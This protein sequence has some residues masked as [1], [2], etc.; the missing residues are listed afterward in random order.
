MGKARRFLPVFVLVFLVQRAAFGQQPLHWDATI[1]TA[2]V[3]ACQS[4]RLVLVLFSAPWCTACHHL[5]NDIRNQP[6]AVAALEGNYV[7]VKINYDYYPNTAKQYG[8]TRLPTTVILAPTARGEVLA[9]IPEYM[10]VDQYL[11]KLNKIAA[12]VKRHDAG[13]YAQIQASPP[14]GAPAAPGQLPVVGPA[15]PANP[16]APAQVA[17]TPRPPEGMVQNTALPA[18]LPAPNVPGLAATGVPAIPANG[19]NN[20][21]VAMATGP[22]LS[23]GRPS[24][25]QRPAANIKPPVTPLFGLDGFCPVQ[26]VEN[27]R[28]QPG[29]KTWG[30]IHR[31]RTYLFAGVDEQR[32]FLAN[33]DR[34]AP[35]SSGNDVVLL[36]EQGR[37]VSGHREH[38]LQFD[39]HVYLFAGEGTLEKF[40]SNPRYYADRALQALRPTSQTAS[41]R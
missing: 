4:N 20:P 39:G 29:K 32:R 38:G 25:P 21:M 24:D 33:P 14:V 13:V 34:Y 37:S 41:V 9:V 6:G 7:P 35:V 3:A 8:V 11:L 30:A 26:L 2:K 1:D 22:G 12:D 19:A 17:A 18:T 40:R 27:A 31:G 15:P 28:W 36:L 5:E 10:P 23:G 16:V